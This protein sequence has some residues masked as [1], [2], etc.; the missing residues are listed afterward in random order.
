MLNLHPLE[1]RPRVDFSLLKFHWTS[2]SQNSSH[3]D[4]AHLFKSLI[5]VGDGYHD[6]DRP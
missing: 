3:G 5:V 1:Q 2:V 4:L 6:L